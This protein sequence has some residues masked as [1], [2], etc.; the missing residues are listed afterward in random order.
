M[1]T[2]SELQTQLGDDLAVDLTRYPA[3]NRLIHIN[4]AIEFLSRRIDSENDQADESFDTTA[5]TQS[6]ALADLFGA[7]KLQFD[8][9]LK[10]YYANAEGNEVVLVQ[11]TEEEFRDEFP[12][13]TDED[14]PTHYM[15]FARKA[16]LGPTP[17]TVLEIFSDYL[18]T[19]NALANPTDTNNWTIYAPNVVLY[20]ASELGAEW[21][22]ETDISASRG[23]RA[24]IELSKL[25]EQ[26][27]RE[28][29]GRPLEMEEQG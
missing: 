8:H 18:G 29:S 1:A 24:D 10:M 21:L 20:R 27:A 19:Q 5:S 23:R 6:Y 2:L 25:S 14:E 9:P 7:A 13:G 3:A 11:L 15:L 22:L 16:Y 12:L 28:L 26:E 4:A 17:A